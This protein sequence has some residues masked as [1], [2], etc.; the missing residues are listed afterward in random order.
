[1]YDY[2]QS[3]YEDNLDQGIGGRRK[4]ISFFPKQ[5]KKKNKQSKKDGFVIDLPIANQREDG[6]EFLPTP[7]SANN[8]K[9]PSTTFITHR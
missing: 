2:Y 8:H 6:V 3:D 1:M 7:S 9:R 5:H 4:T